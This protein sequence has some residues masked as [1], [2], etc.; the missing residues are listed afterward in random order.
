MGRI[1]T[2]LI[3]RITR[4]LLDEHL[5]KFNGDFNDDKKVVTQW[6]TPTSLK[7]R[8]TIAGYVSRLKKKGY[9][10]DVIPN[11]P[12]RPVQTET[13]RRAPSRRY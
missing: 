12:S 8:N 2:K 1:K 5:D 11:R 9:G 7:M 13:T 3:K 4:K 10:T 6:I